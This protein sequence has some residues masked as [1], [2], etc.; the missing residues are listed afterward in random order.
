MKLEQNIFK[1]TRAICKL[2]IALIWVVEVLFVVTLL[3]ILWA[4][5]NG[6]LLSS[7]ETSSSLIILV[8][9]LLIAFASFALTC[10]AQ[11]VLANAIA[12]IDSRNMQAQ[13]FAL[14]NV[15]GQNEQ[16][17]NEHTRVENVQTESSRP[18]AANHRADDFIPDATLDG[19]KPERVT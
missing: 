1:E 17:R 10:V 3:L 19:I 2:A 16:S 14:R 9:G 11:A 4:V 15:Q 7:S 5:S 6:Q 8:G 13:L 18:Y 12:N